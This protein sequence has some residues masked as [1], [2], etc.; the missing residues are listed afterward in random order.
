MGIEKLQLKNGQTLEINIQPGD[1]VIDCGANVGDVTAIFLA[2][3]ANVI[4]FE[5]NPH[6][7]AVLQERYKHFKKA[8]CVNKG[9]S[10]IKSS[11][12][13][14]LFLHE[15]APQNQVMYS[16]GCSIVEYKNNVNKKNFIEVEMVNLCKFLKLLNKEIKVLKVD[17][18]GAEVELLNDL[19]NEGLAR[20]IP[21]I[22]VETHE[23][24]IPE[25]RE[26]TEKLKE[27]VKVEN[28]NNINLNW[29]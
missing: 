7:F 8:K 12:I 27:R 16:T 22:F 2:G 25:L 11:G 3:G 5:P 29:I 4:A 23:E 18:E 21:Y 24:K 15:S 20:D 6:A 19:M 1:Y 28:Y 9:V 13:Q 10:G 17:I 26:E 14:K